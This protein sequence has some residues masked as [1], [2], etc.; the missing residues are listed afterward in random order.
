VPAAPVLKP[1]DV[2]KNEQFISRDMFIEVEHPTLGKIKVLNFPMKFSESPGKVYG[3]APALGQHNE[4]ILTK[5]LR[6]KPEEVEQLRKEG[7]IT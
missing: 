5:I 7:V 6:Y 1:E 3:P 2:V 4:E